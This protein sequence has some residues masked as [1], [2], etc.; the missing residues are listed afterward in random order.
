M[1]AEVKAT[2]SIYLENINA[3]V[4]EVTSFIKERVSRKIHAAMEIN[5]LLKEKDLSV[6][7]FLQ[8]DI[9]V[10]VIEVTLTTDPQKLAIT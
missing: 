2:V 6:N 4:G 1:F 5:A 10:F 9:S 3:V 7:L 8:D